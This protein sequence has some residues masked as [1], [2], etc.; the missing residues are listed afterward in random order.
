M[1]NV[2]ISVSQDVYDTLDDLR[3]IMGTNWSV[4]DLIVYHL[5]DT[6]DDSRA[7]RQ[8][9]HDGFG[10]PLRAPV[11]PNPCSGSCSGK[12][13]KKDTVS[14]VCPVPCD[15]TKLAA[16]QVEAKKEARLNAIASCQVHGPDCICSGGT[17]R[18]N[19][20]NCKT[21]VYEDGTIHCSYRASQYYEGGTCSS[22]P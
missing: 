7:T 9:M 19:S 21:V 4:Q 1:P 6:F 20:N 12:G 2:T 16:M 3:T 8:Y 22:N 5:N 13:L 10:W 15:A 17:Y 18:Q 11:D 14:A